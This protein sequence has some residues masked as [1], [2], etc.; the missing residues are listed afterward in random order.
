[1]PPPGR[2]KIPHAGEY[3]D[4]KAKIVKSGYLRRTATGSSRWTR[5]SLVPT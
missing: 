5:S 3:D 4:E 2:R 1:M